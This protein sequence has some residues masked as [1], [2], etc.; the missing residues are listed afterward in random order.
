MG[1]TPR[2]VD[3]LWLDYQ[4]THDER[5]KAE[6]TRACM[7]KLYA[8]ANQLRSEMGRAPKLQDLVDAGIVGLMEAFDR[9]D[10]TRGVYFET[11]CTL[12]VLGA[13]RDDQ[14][15]KSGATE[16]MLLKAKR[17]RRAA[18]EMTAAHGRPPSDDELAE[19]LGV[20]VADVAGVWRQIEGRTQ[21]SLDGSH[22][23]YVDGAVDLD[24]ALV[25][26]RPDP[27]RRLLAA[28]ARSRLMAALKDLPDKERYTLLLYYFE[29][30]TMAD[31]GLVLDVTESR[32]SQL[33]KKAL[34]T[35]ARRLGPRKDEFLDALGG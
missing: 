19:A 17:L 28:E 31:I 24:R 8:I 11:W 34:A 14:R 1:T 3:Q 29:K 10:P 15:K 5:L 4:R 6:L 30:L 18:E 16:T 23:E 26:P 25:D 13:M 22:A 32:V 9:F 12:R 7:R 33:H 21:V 35:L 20:S 27:S 2:R